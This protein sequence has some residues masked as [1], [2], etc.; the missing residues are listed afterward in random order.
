[1]IVELHEEVW[2]NMTD[3]AKDSLLNKRDVRIR[4][5]DLTRTKRGVKRIR[6]R[7]LEL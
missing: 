2:R 5:Y 1:M 3:I 7:F 4:L 6:E